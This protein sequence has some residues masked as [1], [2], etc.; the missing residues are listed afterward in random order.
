MS[1]YNLTNQFKHR[2]SQQDFDPKPQAVALGEM[3]QQEYDA[4]ELTRLRA[5]EAAARELVAYS[6]HETDMHA[7]ICEHLMGPP[8][9]FPCDCDAPR[10][11]EALRLA[12]SIKT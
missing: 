12:L 8:G 10:L 2:T 4:K 6:N 7:S 9:P 5:I 11:I 1:D 3:T